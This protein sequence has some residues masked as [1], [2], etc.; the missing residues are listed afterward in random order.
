MVAQRVAQVVVDHVEPH[1][2]EHVRV[3]GGDRLEHEQHAARE[4]RVRVVVE[5][6][7]QQVGRSRRPRRRRP[8][9]RARRSRR[10][11]ARSARRPSPRSSC[12]E[13]QPPLRARSR[14]RA[15]RSRRRSRPS[16]HGVPTSPSARRRRA[17]RS[18]RRRAAR[19]LGEAAGRAL[20][21]GGERRER[22]SRLLP[23]GARAAWRAVDMSGD[24]SGSPGKRGRRPRR[25]RPF[26][27]CTANPRLAAL[28]HA[29][30]G[31]SCE[32]PPVPR[33]VPR[34]CQRLRCLPS[35]LRAAGDLER[36]VDL[37]DL[38]VLADVVD[39]RLRASAP[40]RAEVRRR[41]DRRR[42]R[43]AEQPQRERSD[44]HVRRRVERRRADGCRPGS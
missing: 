38:A 41:A 5:P 30:V 10:G 33:A 39:L 40:R 7:A 37:A 27:S 19:P 34:L 25:H 36:L 31:A 29:M 4:V 22:A 21:R 17:G 13:P 24:A 16:A 23:A 12:A 32:A 18:S 20:A 14:A 43:T 6:D 26:W 1:A 44:R 35:G 9:G 11:R 8:G 28:V 15:R 3:A 2:G 42:S